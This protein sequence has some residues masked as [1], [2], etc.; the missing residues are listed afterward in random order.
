MDYF[1]QSDYSNKLIPHQQA[2]F[3]NPE[4]LVPDVTLGCSDAITAVPW[5]PNVIKPQIGLKLFANVR[6]AFINVVTQV[7]GGRCTFCDAMCQ[8]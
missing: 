4:N 2:S 1:F 5:L 8:V 6:G 7:G 3:I